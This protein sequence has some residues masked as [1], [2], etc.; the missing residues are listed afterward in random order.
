MVKKIMIAVVVIAF[1]AHSLCKAAS[2]GDRFI[3]IK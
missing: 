3:R 2:R 1:A